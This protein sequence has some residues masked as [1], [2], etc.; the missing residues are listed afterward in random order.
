MRRA[1]STSVKRT[2]PGMDQA[3]TIFFTWRSMKL[4]IGPLGKPSMSPTPVTMTFFTWVR[5]TT[6][7][8]VEQA[9][10]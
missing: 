3:G 9:F 7:C 8:S 6:S 10:S 1:A 4:T 2:E 5:P